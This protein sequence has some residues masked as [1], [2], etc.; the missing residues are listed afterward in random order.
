MRLLPLFLSPSQREKKRERLNFFSRAE[1]D[2]MGLASWKASLVQ[3]SLTS[4]GCLRSGHQVEL[5]VR[6]Q[7]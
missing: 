4:T 3:D 5:G 6:V 7:E 2:V 1:A